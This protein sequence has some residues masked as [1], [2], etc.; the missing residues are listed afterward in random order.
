VNP[1]EVVITR[2]E[3]VLSIKLYDIVINIPA[4]LLPWLLELKPGE[5]ILT[6]EDETA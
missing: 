2:T 4:E 6:R 3:K 1:N 5:S